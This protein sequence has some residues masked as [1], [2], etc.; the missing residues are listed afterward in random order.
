MPI[1]ANI[2][3][4]KNLAFD[5]V[6]VGGGSAGCALASRISEDS[7]CLVLLIE[8]GNLRKHPLIRVPIGVGKI[9]ARRLFDWQLSSVKTPSLYN[10]EIELMRGKLLGGS[11]AINAMSYVRGA[12]ADYDR[13]RDAGCEGWSFDD[14]EPFFR[15]I[16]TWTGSESSRRGTGGPVTV[17][18]AKSTDALYDAWFNAAKSCGHNEIPF[19]VCGQ[20]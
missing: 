17:S 19:Q 14:V 7:S 10:R 4:L 12:P 5:F 16:E 2:D 15:K 3:D 11:S 9:W 6:I 18:P 1:V 20:K 13:W 8:A